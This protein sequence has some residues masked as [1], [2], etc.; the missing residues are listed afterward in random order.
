MRVL[1]WVDPD[2]ER[3]TTFQT[4]TGTE[5]STTGVAGTT[6]CFLLTC[7]HCKLALTRDAPPWFGTNQSRLVMH[8]LDGRHTQ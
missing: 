1:A 2:G 7:R 4:T 8:L 5:T 3:S 6:S